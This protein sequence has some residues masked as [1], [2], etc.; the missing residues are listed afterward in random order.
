MT[1]D[2][3]PFVGLPYL[4]GGRDR[5][6]VDCWGLVRLVYREVLGVELLAWDTVPATDRRAVRAAAEAEAFARWSNRGEAEARP[7]DVVT[8][9][10]GAHVAVVVERGT[11]L[12]T[13]A[14][15]A[16]CVER[17]GGPAWRSR[18]HGIWRLT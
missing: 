3:T 12:H 4:A 18:W 5:A 9:D 11:M 16:A 14:G 6:G 8:F 13:E 1:F 2:P 10:R 15:R 17:Y 7:L